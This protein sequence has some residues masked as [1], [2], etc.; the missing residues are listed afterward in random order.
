MQTV[1]YVNENE[2]SV[3]FINAVAEACGSESVWQSSKDAD[4]EQKD[5]LDHAIESA[6]LVLTR[7]KM[8]AQGELVSYCVKVVIDQL[9]TRVDVLQSERKIN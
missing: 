7:Y 3:S 1:N 8:F 2:E 9:A 6:A 5:A 4:N